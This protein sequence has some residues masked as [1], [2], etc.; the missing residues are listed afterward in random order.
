MIFLAVESFQYAEHPHSLH[1]SDTSILP[2]EYKA[3]SIAADSFF[4][5]ATIHFLLLVESFV[6][7]VVIS[8]VVFP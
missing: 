5:H 1:L 6:S 8:C 2:N 4:H 7:H 3:E